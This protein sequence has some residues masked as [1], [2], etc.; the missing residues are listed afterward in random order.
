[1]N[2]ST[3]IVNQQAPAPVPVEVPDAGDALL[4][5]LQPGWRRR[6]RRFAANRLAVVGLTLTLVLMLVGILAPLITPATYDDTS[7]VANTYAFPSGA[8]WFGVN[9]VGRDFAPPAWALP[10]RPR[11]PPQHR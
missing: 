6:L 9:A 4:A 7:F 2:Q 3:G 8:H 10:A 1:M 11:S 5:P